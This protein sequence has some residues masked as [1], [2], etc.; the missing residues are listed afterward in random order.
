MNKKLQTISAQL[1]TSLELEP[2]T[3]HHCQRVRTL[4]LAIGENLG[5][6]SSELTSLACGSLLHDIGKKRIPREIVLKPTSLTEEEW[7]TMKQHPIHGW[8][9]AK[10]QILAEDIQEIILHHHLWYDGSG[11]YPRNGHPRRPGYLTQI[12]SVAD[13]VDA[14]IHDRPYRRALSF[15]T[16]LDFLAEQSGTQ[17]APVVVES[18]E[19]NHKQFRKLLG[20]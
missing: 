17:F 10:E 20:A 9:Y 13:V 15:D 7:E 5:L 2:D 18:V 3:L 19:R 6:T 4:S 12:V 16:S 11:G 1:S 14:M 8:E